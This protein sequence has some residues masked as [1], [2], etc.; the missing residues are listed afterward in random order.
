MKGLKNICNK[1]YKSQ[2]NE[3]DAIIQGIEQDDVGNVTSIILDDLRKI[4]GDLFLDLTGFKRVL[5]SRLYPFNNS[6]KDYSDISPDSAM[7]YPRKYTNPALQIMGGTKF[8][9]LDYGWGFKI[10]LYHRTGNGYNFMS[11]LADKNTIYDYMQIQAGDFKINNPM[12]ISWNPGYYE[13][14]WQGNT[15]ALGIAAGLIH[16]FDGNTITAHSK[17]LESLISMLINKPLSLTEMEEQFN[18]RQKQ[19]LDEIE[20]RMTLMLG[21]SKRSGDFWELQRQT[22]KERNYLE[23]LQQIIEMQTTDINKVLSHNWQQA[24]IRLAVSCGVDVSNFNLP[25]PTDSDIE[26]AK[27]FFQYNR[28]INKYIR[29]H[30]WPNYYEWLKENRFGGK[31]SNEIFEELN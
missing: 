9:G 16:P 21:F 30:K 8:S 28:A 1:K 12:V 27:A 15:V 14:P 13:K 3:V 4:T 17:G 6:W 19:V 29:E 25:K 2:I 31:T 23:K 26:M 24:Y 10:N 18:Q 7:V 22:A 20:M 5:I 11:K